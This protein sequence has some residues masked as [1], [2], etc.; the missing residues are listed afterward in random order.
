MVRIWDLR[1]LMVPLSYFTEKPFQNWTHK[2]ADLLGSV[3]IYTDYAVPVEALRRE[4]A[5]ILKSMDKWT[6]KVFQHSPH[7]SSQRV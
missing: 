4:L 1:R 2:T 6:G 5:R 3:F 7:V